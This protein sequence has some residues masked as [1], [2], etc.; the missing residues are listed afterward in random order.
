MCK[1]KKFPKWARHLQI[2]FL[3]QNWLI[4]IWSVSK[5]P[6]TKYTYLL[7]SKTSNVHNW[8][9]FPYIHIQYYISC[10][11]DTRFWLLTLPKCINTI[12]A[13]FLLAILIVRIPKFLLSDIITQS[14]YCIWISWTHLHQSKKNNG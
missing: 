1:K 8:P 3:Q 12:I 7:L 5:H 2:P 6:K 4:A 11:I 9:K 13:R 10:N 14:L